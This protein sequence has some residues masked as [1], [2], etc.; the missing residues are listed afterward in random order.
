MR[1]KCGLP[2]E[3]TYIGKSGCYTATY[4]AISHLED[5]RPP[6][7]N[8][9]AERQLLQCPEC[10]YCTNFIFAMED[11]LSTHISV[12]PFQCSHCGRRFKRAAHLVEHSRIHTGEKPFYCQLCP[13]TFT[14]KASLVRH[15]RAHEDKKR[16]RCHFCSMAFARGYLRTNHEIKKHGRSS[17]L[18]SYGAGFFAVHDKDG[19]PLGE[20]RSGQG[21]L[22]HCAVCNYTTARRSHMQ[23]HQRA[24]TG[25]RPHLCSYCNKGFVKKCH[26]VTHL[27]IHTGEKPYKCHMCPMAF[28]QKITLVAHLRAHTG[29]KPFRCHFCPKA[30]ALRSKMRYHE[31][32]DHGGRKYAVFHGA[33]LDATRHDHDLPLAENTAGK[34]Q[35]L[36]CPVCNYF[37]PFS[38]NMKMH[39]RTHTGERPFQCSYCGKRF[40][41]TGHLKKHI[42]IHTGEKQF[43]CQLC[44]V[45]FT[46]KAS[47]VRH[48]QAHA[49][50]R[51]GFHFCSGTWVPT[52]GQ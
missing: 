29:D 19:M 2:S 3:K 6:V 4:P 10:S 7:Q 8:L 52:V 26:L 39:L 44:P 36:H 27:R 21:Q 25:E 35:L 13:L 17:A 47:L 34:G 11:H 24:H 23:Y 9:H 28:T 5:V 37:T 1:C 20:G 18:F 33:G 30:F 40:R 48:L 46:Q 31:V 43:Q 42:R 22:L 32:R 14:Q 50:K 41:Q 49:G 15:M 16:F 12:R 51:I 38:G 45:S